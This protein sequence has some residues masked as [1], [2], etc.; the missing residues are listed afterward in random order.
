M[1]MPAGLK[2]KGVWTFDST[3]DAVKFGQDNKGNE[4]I[5]MILLQQ[6]SNQAT[7]GQLIREALDELKKGDK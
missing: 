6:M 2:L 5:E 7:Y 3:E 4:K 1:I